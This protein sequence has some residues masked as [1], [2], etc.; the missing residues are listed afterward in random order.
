[1]ASKNSVEI[2]IRAQDKASSIA[3]RVFSKFSDA[4]QK[5]MQVVANGAAVAGAAL[6]GLA[7]VGAKTGVQFN[8][9]MEQALISFETLLGSAD[10]AKKMVGDLQKFAATTPFEFPGI[11]D[12]AKLMLAMG[13]NA[14]Q[15]MPNL[16][17]VG[18]AVAAIG[19]NEETL[20]GVTMALGQMLTKGKVSAEE[21]NQL[22]ER[23]IGAWDIMSQKLGKSKQELM[24]MA[25]EG[26]LMADVALPALIEGMG[27]KFAGAMDK[28][29]KTFTGM[30][31]T[32]RDNMNM[33]LGALTQPLFESLKSAM[34]A[35]IAFTDEF[36]KNIETSGV[37]GALAA[38]I[39]DSMKDRLEEVK[40]YV[41]EL[42]ANL[43]QG[44]WE[45]IGRQIGLTIS[46]AFQSLSD[47]GQKFEDWLTNQLS[48]VK[49][50]EVGRKA[51]VYTTGFVLGFVEGLLD[52]FLWIEIFAQNWDVILGLLITI[53]FAPAKWT[54]KIAQALG[55][56]P[57]VG[58]MTEWL[59]KKIID[60]GSW[61]KDKAGQ[62]FKDFGG[63]LM[64]GLKQAVGWKGGDLL[65]TLKGVI[66]KAL[67][68]IKGTGDDLYKKGL[69]WMRNLGM[70]IGNH[71]PKQIYDSLKRIQE[72]IDV[73]VAIWVD[74]ALRMGRDF[75]MGIVRGFQEKWEYAKT[76]AYNF[77]QDVADAVKNFFKIKSP[78]RLMAEYGRYI[79]EGL[80]KGM[81][82]NKD[83]PV[84]S[85][86]LMA[87]AIT[88]A[89]GKV[90]QRINTDLEIMNAEFAA[91]FGANNI[92]KLVKLQGELQRFNKEMEI[93]NNR[94]V[95][96]KQAHNDVAYE[97]GEHSQEAKDLYLQIVKEQAAQVEL[98]NKIE[99]TNKAIED[100]KKQMR[101]LQQ[102]VADVVTKFNRDLAQAQEDYE[103]K[104]SE[105]NKKLADGIRDL[106]DQYQKAVADRSKSLA[107]F[108]GLFDS[109]GKKN[110]SGEGLLSNLRS[111]LDAFKNWAKNIAE[112]AK[113]GISGGLLEQLRQMG[114]SAGA[115]ITAL[116][117]LTN[118]QLSE[119][120]TLWQEKQAL[121]TTEATA[122]LESLKEQTAQKISE[123]IANTQVQL[124]QY[125]EEWDKKNAEIVAELV[126]SMQELVEKAKE[127]GTEFML[128]LGQ[129][130]DDQTPA[131]LAKLGS[132]KSQVESIVASIRSSIQSAT[133]SSLSS[134]LETLG[135]QW[136]ATTDQ[137]AR[138]AIHDQANAAREA[139]GLRAG[140]DY[141]PD[142]GALLRDIPGLA[143]GGT[144]TK[145][146][147]VLVGEEGPELLNLPRGASVVP[148][149]KTGQSIH[150][151]IPITF[152]QPVYGLS[153]FKD[154]VKEVIQESV[155]PILK[156][157][158]RQPARARGVR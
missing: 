4:S 115:E 49:W 119:Y 5:A 56:I 97:L 128:S 99:D 62:M 8:A 88:D 120:A 149:D 109:V 58:T 110:V 6:T 117:S 75:I 36:K 112:L 140:I 144:V 61:I 86:I 60:I 69:E 157:Q 71:G 45:D 84:S 37:S 15:I 92:S 124:T 74:D 132:I 91:T 141:D 33:T 55:K 20:Q 79:A 47:F 24:K 22:A 81:E 155:V 123:L 66:N 10:K 118:E 16:K 41:S 152:N 121:A 106:N 70:S 73:G 23:G 113:R 39:P 126:K 116:N 151:T 135:E 35:V 129:A 1:M 46:G 65:P 40:D 125:K 96:L 42:R 105:A 9:N 21:M 13:F 57:F 34:P 114:P 53:M 12:S 28:Q 131:L 137:A 143:T 146:G 44:D 7:A 94:L 68:G 150:I 48:Q 26:K 145:P 59:L 72:K 104:V 156:N 3:D 111:Q 90:L 136:N 50:A 29:S 95:L 103:K 153:D 85:A 139:A 102:E 77:A 38:M 134:T 107:N 2:V 11:Q 32:I 133:M 89:V 78:S 98:K 83:N 100:Q 19:G 87:K 130:L 108:V 63:A 14:E 154:Q 67:D 101:A 127:G 82:E 51:V 93:S 17:A 64:D 138:D 27:T 31:S 18:D 80:A 142:S 54:M 30:M 76:M 148:L 147:T 43:E 122:E 158:L 52:P 25:E